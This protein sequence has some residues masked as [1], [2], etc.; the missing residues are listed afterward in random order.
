[1]KKIFLCVSVFLLLADFLKAQETVYPTKE[2]KSKFYIVNG[3]V[4]VGNGTVIENAT[5]EVNNGKIV[6]VGSN[7]TTAKDDKVFDA[8]G[9]EVYPG[10]ILTST[11]L[12]LKEIANGVREVMIM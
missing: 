4:H 10:L 7:I 2:F 6:R 1:M 8:K 5:V 12:G 9:K 11:D 3:T